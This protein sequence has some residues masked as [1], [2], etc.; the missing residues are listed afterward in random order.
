MPAMHKYTIGLGLTCK[1]TDSLAVKVVAFD[2][3]FDKRADQRLHFACWEVEEL[4]GL[5]LEHPE[6]ISVFFM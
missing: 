6:K 4:V 2:A 5:E 3:E 1:D